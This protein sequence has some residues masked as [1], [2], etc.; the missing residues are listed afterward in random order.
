L[1]RF[2]LLGSGSSGNAAL[3]VSGRAKIL[4][5]DGFSF[6]QLLARTAEIGESLDGLDA[7]FVTHEHQD[8]V[9]GIGVLARRMDVPIFMTPQ[10]YAGL[11]PS[12]GTVRRIEVFE[13]GDAIN[14]GDLEVRSFSVS[15]DAADP[16]SYSVHHGAAK[17]GFA[18]DF[19]HSSHLVRT[20]LAGSHALVLESNYCPD[21]LRR[22]GYPPQVQQRIRSRSGHLSNQDMS[23]LLSELLHEALRTV[24][25]V[26]ISEN[27][28]TPELVHAMASQVVKHRAIEVFVA[29][30]DRPTRLFEVVP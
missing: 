21:M 7:V 9:A 12:L 26:H 30:Q 22:G 2:S 4:I 24:V 13:G 16:V 8:H 1:L 19:G 20:R 14:V 15:H 5:D 28:N 25:L 17:L 29:A 18:T 23:S 10:T 3:I 6:K 27:N 11:P